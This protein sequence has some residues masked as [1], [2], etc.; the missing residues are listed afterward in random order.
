QNEIAIVNAGNGKKSYI[1]KSDLRSPGYTGALNI[2][3]Q[4]D[5]QQYQKRQKVN[6]TLSS[7]PSADFSVSVYKIDS[8]ISEDLETINA[9]TASHE[10]IHDPSQFSYPPEYKSHVINGRMISLNTRMPSKNVNGYLTIMDEANSFYNARTDNNGK[11]KFLVTKLNA[12][13]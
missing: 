9:L 12:A 10:R 7:L 4:T 11:V 1:L 3:L 2:N 13:D 8:L 5:R 6:V